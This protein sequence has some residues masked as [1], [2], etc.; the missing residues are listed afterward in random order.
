MR[1]LA[2]ST[3]S[4]SLLAPLLPERNL[5]GLA[6][7]P[8]PF[9]A[10]LGSTNQI[11]GP[12]MLKVMFTGVLQRPGAGLPVSQTVNGKVTVP[13]LPGAGSKVKA[14]VV[15]LATTVPTLAMVAVMVPL[16]G[17]TPLTVPTVSVA[18]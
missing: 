17:A 12:A 3:S 4:A 14:A 7:V 9:V 2:A 16:T 5:N 15:A 11:T 13:V 18:V 6:R 1:W 8:T 10:A